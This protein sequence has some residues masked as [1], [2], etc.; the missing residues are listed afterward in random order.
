MFSY[1]D[2]RHTHVNVSSIKLI[3]DR[4]TLCTYVSF[5]FALRFPFFFQNIKVRERIVQICSVGSFVWIGT[6]KGIK[7]FCAL[8]YKPVAFGF[9]EFRMILKIL[10]SPLCGTVLVSLSDGSIFAF[11]DNISKYNTT[12][13]QNDVINIFHNVD[14]TSVIRKLE[15]IQ[16]YTSNFKTHCMTGVA[17]HASF[18]EKCEPEV[19]LDDETV[20]NSEENNPISESGEL[21]VE[22]WC[23]QDKGRILILDVKTLSVKH[24]LCVFQV[25]PP[26]EYNESFSVQFIETSRSFESVVT[27]NSN[28]NK[29]PTPVPFDHPFMWVVV[30]P[31]TQV[32]RWNVKERSVE[33]SLDITQHPPWHDCKLFCF[34]EVSYHNLIPVMSCKT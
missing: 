31:G 17:F 23:G 7:V 30:Y 15:E 1:H 24:T 27:S 14:R 10:H 12:I 34:C 29:S 11:H 19:N 33:C 25:E 18:S 3:T 13:S 20:S 21:T 4:N 6:E 8:T 5:L 22:V 9:L 2:G 16:R 28:N 32:S 26:K